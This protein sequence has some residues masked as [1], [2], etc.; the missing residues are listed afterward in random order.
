MLKLN[1]TKQC[2]KDE[3]LAELRLN[4]TEG[5]LKILAEKS[6]KKGI[7][8]LIKEKSKYI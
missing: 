4:L 1:T 2:K 3:Y 7:N 5:S 8:K 6:R